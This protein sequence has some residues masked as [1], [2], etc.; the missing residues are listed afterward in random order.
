M[1][2][3]ARMSATPSAWPTYPWP[4]TSPMSN[5]L[6][7]IRYAECR[8]AARRSVRW[9]VVD[10]IMAFLTGQ[11]GP[12]RPGGMLRNNQAALGPLPLHFAFQSCHLVPLCRT[13]GVLG[14]QGRDQ[15]QEPVEAEQEC[16]GD[17]AVPTVEGRGEQRGEAGDDR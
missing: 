9:S 2:A 15:A 12:V 17:P 16:G 5:A 6:R 14:D 4:C 8:S 11:L 13:P 3:T 7:R 1:Y 10:V